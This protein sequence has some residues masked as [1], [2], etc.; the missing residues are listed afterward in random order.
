MT[1]GDMPGG[2]PKTGR[3]RG[4]QGR[5]GHG[6]ELPRQRCCGEVPRARSRFSASNTLT[7]KR[8]AWTRTA[9]LNVAGMGAFSS[10][11]TIAQYAH[12]IWQTKPVVLG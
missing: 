12:D 9:I 5:G 10:D 6:R 4:R 8:H 11:R 7:T 2:T 1:L 3:R